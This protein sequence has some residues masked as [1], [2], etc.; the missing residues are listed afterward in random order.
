MLS[1]NAVVEHPLSLFSNGKVLKRNLKWMCEVLL[2]EKVRPWGGVSQ[3]SLRQISYDKGRAAEHTQTLTRTLASAKLKIDP[4][5]LRSI[6]FFLLA[7]VLGHPSHLSF[8]VKDY[9]WKCGWIR[10]VQRKY[11]H[12]HFGVGD[13]ESARWDDAH[14]VTSGWY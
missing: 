13:S 14:N 3:L 1:G 8:G 6:S 4:L 5:G 7:S 2:Y 9:C 10:L 12:T 11:S